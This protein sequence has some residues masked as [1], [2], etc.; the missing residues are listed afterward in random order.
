MRHPGIPTECP[1]Q[2]LMGS[3]VTQ[4]GSG[5]FVCL[6]LHHQVGSHGD[7]LKRKHTSLY[8]LSQQAELERGE[9]SELEMERVLRRSPSPLHFQYAGCRR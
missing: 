4:N 7:P 5:T 6:S 3:P 2:C 8:L 9:K 1:A